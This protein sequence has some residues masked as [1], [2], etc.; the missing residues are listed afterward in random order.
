MEKGIKEALKARKKAHTPYSHFNVGAAVLMNNGKYVHGCNVEISNY[1][2]TL[3]AERNALFSSYA[4]GY[5]KKDIKALYIVGQTPKAISPCGACRQ[6]ISD[7][8]P[9]DCKI[10]LSNLDASDVKV[11]TIDEL[12]P[13]AFIEDDLK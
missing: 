8:C 12:L 3:C 4:Q 10:V 5:T 11:C 1:N 2:S 7:L 6:V 13:Y 9:R